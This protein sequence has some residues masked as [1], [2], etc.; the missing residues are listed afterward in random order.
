MKRLNR[1]EVSYA[2]S[3]QA[4]KDGFDQDVSLLERFNE[5]INDLNLHADHYLTLAVNASLYSLPVVE[6]EN[7]IVVQNLS[8]ADLIKLYEYYFRGK[9]PGRTLYG[10]LMSAA[11]EECPFCGGIGRPRNLDHFMPKALF[12]QFSVLPINLIPSCR[13]CNMD[14]KGNDFAKTP[15]TQILHPYLDANHFF[16]DQW[17]VAK[18][19]LGV[20]NKPNIIEYYVDP[21]DTWDDTDKARVQQHFIDFDIAKRYSVL[22][23]AALTE[24]EAQKKAFLKSANIDRFKEVI[25]QPIIGLKPFANHWKHVMF[26]ALINDL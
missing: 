5:G 23:S 12:P 17:L 16:E 26:I 4:C 14:G 11:S 21:P 1:P 9:F 3:L 6:G 2:E 24:V 19:V 7:P 20:G 15:E 25:L 8:K 10:K 13:D 18:Y 22:A